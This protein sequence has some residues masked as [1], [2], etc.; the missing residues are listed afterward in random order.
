MGKV[1]GD[2]R[3]LPQPQVGEI[4]I[5]FSAKVELTATITSVETAIALE[6]FH[7]LQPEV[8]RER[9]AYDEAP[10]IHVAFVRVFRLQ[11]PW[12]LPDKPQYGGCRSW[13]QLPELAS[14]GAAIEPVLSDSEHSARLLAFRE[15]VRATVAP[16]E[17]AAAA[18]GSTGF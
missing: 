15:I 14:A 4:E 18:L 1:R 7:I 2:V 6:R 8:V 17:G 13:V 10:G 3:E 16:P 5:Q 11:R 9:F 12:R